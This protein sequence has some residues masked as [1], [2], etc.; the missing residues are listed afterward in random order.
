[1]AGNYC[2][3]T[4]INQRGRFEVLGGSASY[5]SAVLSSLETRFEVVARVGSDF[6][7]AEQVLKAPRVDP[8]GVTTHFVD[9]FTS[10]V[11]ESLLVAESAPLSASDLGREPSRIGLACGVAREVQ[12]ET[13]LRLKAL[14]P[15]V[16]ADIQGLIRT[17]L[18]DGRLGK[19][20]FA[21]TA[22]AS[23]VEQI[24]YLKIGEEELPYVDV[25]ELSR[26]TALL[27][28]RG[29]LG[30]SLVRAGQEIRV[31][32]VPADEID[33]SG[34]GDCFTAGFAYGLLRSPDPIEAMR[35]GNRFGALAVAQ[36][37]IPD[38]GRVR[39]LES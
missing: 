13:L 15:I 30:S 20:F 19:L 37:G 39:S 24:D 8:T 27:L 29:R 34:A 31:S 5:I 22:F 16:V 26:K 9:D 7:Y 32:A 4:L 1:V 17:R 38:F 36:V 35:W 23:V 28:T 2:H 25:A 33:S 12:P 10:G 6:K 3:D 11:R 21:D 18:S 14:C